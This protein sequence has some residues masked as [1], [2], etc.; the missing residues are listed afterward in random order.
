MCLILHN[1]SVVKSRSTRRSAQMKRCDRKKDCLHIFIERKSQEI[2]RNLTICLLLISGLHVPGYKVN[3]V[4]IVWYVYEIWK[5]LYKK[6]VGNLITKVMK[7]ELTCT[8]WATTSCTV[9]LMIFM[10]VEWVLV[11]NLYELIKLYFAVDDIEMNLSIVL[12]QE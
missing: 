8:V 4:N 1:Q 5:H 3:I 7:F 10:V 12:S 2:L 9:P 11:I 6:N